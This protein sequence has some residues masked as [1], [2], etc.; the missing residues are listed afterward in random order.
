M[1]EL[2]T[3]GLNTESNDIL[4]THAD[5]D[6]QLGVRRAFALGKVVY[7]GNSRSLRLVGRA[8]LSSSDMAV[9]AS[10]GR[11]RFRSAEGIAVAGR[12]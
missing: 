9:D 6:G 11:Q 1:Q 8:W 10:A 2:F 4:G 7:P 12:S 3:Q 5:S